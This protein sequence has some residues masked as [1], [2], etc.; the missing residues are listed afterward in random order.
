MSSLQQGECDQARAKKYLFSA[1]RIPWRSRAPVGKHTDRCSPVGLTR[2]QLYMC[3]C[4]R[5]GHTGDSR[6]PRY[7]CALMQ[8]MH[9]ICVGHSDAY[10][11]RSSILMNVKAA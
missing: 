1:L 10:S 3:V 5:Q 4:F 11:T 6:V 2:Y 8:A 7:R 9:A